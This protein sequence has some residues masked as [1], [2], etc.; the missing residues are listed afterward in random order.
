MARFGIVTAAKGR[1]ELARCIE[2][3]QDQKFSDFTHI[4]V[5]D[6]PLDHC[7]RDM[8]KVRNTF[9]Y[10]TRIKMEGFG[11]AARTVALQIFEQLMPV[12]YVLIVDDDNTLFSTALYELDKAAKDNPP[13]MFHDIIFRNAFHPEWHIFSPR[14]PPEGAMW[15]ALHM[16]LIHI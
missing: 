6:G 7:Y 3:I 13:L 5:G 9:Y 15:D 16:S 4:V 10:Q 1:P 2:S 8:C 11:G 12:D 14:I